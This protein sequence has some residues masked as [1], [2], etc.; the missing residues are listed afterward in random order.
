VVND[1]HDGLRRQWVPGDFAVEP[2]QAQPSGDYA[3]KMPSGIIIR[4][5]EMN[6]LAVRPVIRSIFSQGETT[7][8]DSQLEKRAIA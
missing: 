5:G 6:D 1:R 2:V 3:G 7:S 4:L 8:R